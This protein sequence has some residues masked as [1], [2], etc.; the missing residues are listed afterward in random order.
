LKHI[1]NAAGD[2]GCDIQNDA[3]LKVV[4][5]LDGQRVGERNVAHVEKVAFSVQ[6]ANTQHRLEQP[7]FNPRDLHRERRNYKRLGLTGT[8]VIEW[9][10]PHHLQSSTN[11]RSERKVSSRFGH[12]IIINRRR[13]RGFVK[14]LAGFGRVAI[15]Q[16]RSNVE[17]PA[18]WCAV[19]DGV[20]NIARAA[21]MYS[22]RRLGLRGGGSNC[23][24]PSKMKNVTGIVSGDGRVH[25]GRVG[26]IERIHFAEKGMRA[27]SL[28]CRD[29]LDFRA[30]CAAQRALDMRA[31]EAIR[32][33]HQNPHGHFVRGFTDAHAV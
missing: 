10:Q 22:P 32:T 8:G 25:G 13:R 18:P 27:T 15:D 9:A 30:A 12:A 7:G 26:D 20:G 17:Q 33:G 14:G 21:D 6:V 3:R 16:S 29:D 4:G 11:Q 23:C 24:D 28:R 31:D 1:A 19:E 5:M 2:A